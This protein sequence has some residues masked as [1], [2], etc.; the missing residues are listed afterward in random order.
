MRKIRLLATLTILAF[1]PLLPAQ[2]A[3]R[4]ILTPHLFFVG[5]TAELK[6]SFSSEI[7]FVPT[8]EARARNQINSVELSQKSF[9]RSPDYSD[10]SIKKI[11]LS[12]TGRNQQNQIT[13]D[14]SI[15]FVPWKP[16]ELC[17]PPYNLAQDLFPGENRSFILS[18]S[19][20]TVASIFEQRGI[21]K[22]FVPEKGPLLVPGTT[23][24]ILGYSILLLVLL[25]ILIRIAVKYRNYSLLIRNLKLRILYRRNRKSAVRKLA[26]LPGNK[27]ADRENAEIIQ[28]I[29][30]SYLQVRFD[31]PFTKSGSSE[32]TTGF[33]RIYGD[34]LSPEKE[35]AV[36]ELAGIFIRT[37]YIRYGKDNHFE[38]D[39]LKLLSRKLIEIIETLESDPSKKAGGD[40]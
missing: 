30:R 31:Y 6:L 33:Y 15:L 37:D 34:L 2:N 4:Q 35:E 24:R 32:I 16:G 9:T 5:D 11:V 27:K 14:F 36:D 38:K 13:Y 1:S 25:L 17:F 28:N 40:K 20:F 3:Q 26:A 10:Y 21:G 29:M 12:K 18:P 23:Y 22:A 8:T 7:D 39:G 19:E